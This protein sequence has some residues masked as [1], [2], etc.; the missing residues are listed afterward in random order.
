MTLIE[1]AIEQIRED[2]ERD[3][4]IDLMGF[5]ETVPEWKLQDYLRPENNQEDGFSEF[6]EQFREYGDY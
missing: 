3:N 5:L 1:S 6:D 2:L 4:L